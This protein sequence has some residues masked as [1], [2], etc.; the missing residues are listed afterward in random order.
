[1]GLASE[2]YY[3]SSGQKLYERRLFK[4]SFKF[5]YM[6]T[7][8]YICHIGCSG[9]MVHRLGTSKQITARQQEREHDDVDGKDKTNPNKTTEIGY[10]YCCVWD[11]VC[12]LYILNQMLSYMRT[13]Y[14]IWV[15]SGRM[16]STERCS[17]NINDFFRLQIV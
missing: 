6:T 12:S 8:H 16:W 15:V 14:V 11:I 7:R 5:G 3:F 13:A 10:Y 4:R 17:G 2:D 9:R 1:M